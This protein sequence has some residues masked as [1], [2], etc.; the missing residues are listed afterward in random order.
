MLTRFGGFLYRARWFVLLAGLA[1]VFAAG[2]F[3]GGLFGLLKSGG[4][5]DPNSQSTQA[6]NV[7]DQQLGGSTTDVVILMRS[8]TLNATDPA[9]ADAATQMLN[10]LQARTEVAS[11]ISYYSTQSA[12]FLARDGHETFAVVREGD[13]RRGG[14]RPLGVLDDFGRCALHDGDA[15]IGRA[16][17]DAN[18]LSHVCPLFPADRPGLSI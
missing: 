4:F 14:A 3:G 13:D 18:D 15:G 6:Q 9:F 7:L 10:T 12:R 16:E 2:A 11:V 17:V 5:Q 1:L 8:D